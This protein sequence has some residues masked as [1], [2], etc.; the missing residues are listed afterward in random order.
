MAAAMATLPTPPHNYDIDALVRELVASKAELNK[1]RLELEMLRSSGVPEVTMNPHI[2]DSLIDASADMRAA[3]VT[4]ASALS[5]TSQNGST[6]ALRKLKLTPFK[7]ADEKNSIR[8]I[9][10]RWE[11]EFEAAGQAISVA[12]I[13]DKGMT[14]SHPLYNWAMGYR[15]RSMDSEGQVQINSKDPEDIM[16]WGAERFKHELQ[17]FHFY[18]PPNYTSIMKKIE[19]ASCPVLGNAH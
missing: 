5:Y 13:T 19:S 8:D 7:T 9:M 12:F 2:S 16:N 11:L 15:S 14:A 1:S 18:V 3:L 10:Y 17:S 6:K 4:T